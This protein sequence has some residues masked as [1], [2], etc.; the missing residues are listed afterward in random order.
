M[1]VAMDRCVVG[2]S[3]EELREDTGEG[4]VRGRFCRMFENRVV[5]AVALLATTGS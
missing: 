5:R 3:G 1:N 4:D 2:R